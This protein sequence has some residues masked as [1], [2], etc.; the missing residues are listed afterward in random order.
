MKFET[1][2][3][4]TKVC[5]IE[6]FD[7]ESYEAAK[8]HWN[9]IAKP[10]YG[11]GRLEEITARIAGIQAQKDFDLSKRAI[12]V[13]C[14]DNGIV[15][16]GVTQTDSTVTAIVAKNMALRT[17]SVCKMAKQ[18]GIDVIPVDIGISH[19]ELLSGIPKGS[20][21]SC[22]IKPGTNNFAKMPAM[23]EAE[24]KKAID[25][26]IDL[27]RQCKDKGYTML[28]VGEMGIGN[29]TTASAVCAV[30]LSKE[31]KAVTG[32]GAGL[33]NEG[34]KKK[35]SVIERA[36]STYQLTADQPLKV[37]SCVGGLDIAGLVGVLI[38][39]A[40][41]RIPVVLDGII[42]GAAA[43][44][45]KAIEPG[46][47]YAMLAS[48]MGKEPA[49]RAVFDHLVLEPVIYA[50]LALGEG[51]GATLLFPMLDMAQSVYMEN[52]TFDEM[53]IPAYQEFSEE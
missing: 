6:Q 37:L 43:L 10:L 25:V 49:M 39:G 5:C 50:E 44:L 23:T 34:L 45:A 53:H 21:L 51:T 12:I 35:I 13:M 52:D 46:C 3:D 2:P 33:G 36:I 14:A 31:V 8:Q 17:S 38:G 22:S 47:E 41:Y 9:E 18:A 30:M 27:V 32:R 24:A 20:L 29:T 48:H 11:L 7:K 42:T 40:R 16:E 1:N 4:H 19:K 28:S 26:G 15:E